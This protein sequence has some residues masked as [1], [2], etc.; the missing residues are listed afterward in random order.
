MKTYPSPKTQYPKPSQYSPLQNWLM[1]G[2]IACLP[3][4]LEVGGYHLAPSDIFLMAMLYCIPLGLVQIKHVRSSWSLW[5]FGMM[6]SVCAALVVALLRTGYVSDYALINKAIGMLVL[7]AGYAVIAGQADSWQRIRWMARLLITSVA[8]QNAIFVA[9]FMLARATGIILPIPHIEEPRL[10]GLLIDP[11][12]YG[13]LLAMTLSIQMVTQY[14]E[15]PLIGGLIGR[16]VTITLAMGMVLTYS[17]SA[18]IGVGAVFLIILA[19][20]PKTGLRLAR[21]GAIAILMI[22][23]VLGPGYMGDISQLSSRGTYESRIFIINEAIPMFWQSPAIG[24]G[25]GVFEERAGIIIHNT[26]MWLLTECGVI[27]L[28]IFTCFVLWF[29]KR[30]VDTYRMAGFAE[31]PLVLGLITASL[32]M[33]GLSLGIEAL[34]QRHLWLIWALIAASYSVQKR[35]IAARQSRLAEV[36]ECA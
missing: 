27:G 35:D 9:A 11:N 22:I 12:A 19:L 21:T 2:Y 34:Y 8:A 4:Q 29:L 3:I 5:H 13:G 18:W 14:E 15:E 33:L 10:A 30:G 31:K 28:G 26:P 25:L 17:R 32:A 7:F 24:I 20:R 23:L 1:A 36:R 6:F 16:L